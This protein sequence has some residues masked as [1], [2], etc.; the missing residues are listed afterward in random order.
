MKGKGDFDFEVTCKTAIV[1][2]FICVLPILGCQLV[3]VSRHWSEAYETVKRIEALS[4]DSEFRSTYEAKLDRDKEISLR[5]IEA[6]DT[7]DL[8]YEERSLLER[9]VSQAMTAD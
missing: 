6:V 1:L 5:A 2:F 8:G 4:S 3:L 9:I 7:G